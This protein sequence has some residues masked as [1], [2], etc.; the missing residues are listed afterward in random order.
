MRLALNL[1]FAAILTLLT[2]VG[3]L[4]WLF[5]L[6]F[7]LRLLAFALAYASLSIASLW[8]APVFGRVPLSCGGDG[9]MRVQSWLYCALNRQYVTPELRDTAKDLAAHLAKQFPGTVTLILDANFPFLN[10]FPLLPHLSH[11]DGR[12]LD[13]AFYYKS[14][15]SYVPSA[16]RSPVGYFAF[17]QG[18]TECPPHWLTLRWDL[19]WLQPLMADLQPEPQRIHAAL[20]WLSQDQRVRKVFV[21]PHLRERFNADFPKLRFQGCRAARHDDHIHFEL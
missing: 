16:T 17:E 11:D 21:E 8:I 3:G 14:G 6:N 12:K 2:Q 18:A 10:G 7:R 4:A 13:L 15:Q 20:D 19:T 9:S 5:A 1:A